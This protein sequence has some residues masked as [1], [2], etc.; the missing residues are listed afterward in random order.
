M[1][2][3]ML[4]AFLCAALAMTT[5]GSSAQVPAQETSPGPEAAD[6]ALLFREDP[7][8]EPDETR[9]DDISADDFSTFFADD[10]VSTD[11][12]YDVSDNDSIF[13]DPFSEWELMSENREDLFLTEDE[14]AITE[15]ADPLLS[16]EEWDDLIIDEDFFIEETTIEDSLALASRLNA[17]VA[18]RATMPDRGK[19]NVLGICVDFADTSFDSADTLDAFRAL[20][21][22]SVTQGDMPA[23]GFAGPYESLN[24]Y[25]QRSSLGLLDISADVFS[26]HS[27][28]ER[29]WYEEDSDEEQPG[30]D[31]IES[32]VLEVLRALDQDV[33]YSRYD[34]DGD[35]IIDCVFIHFAGGDTGWSSTWWSYANG[36]DTSEAAEQVSYDG[37]KPGAYV[38][39]H[40][41]SDQEAACRT[42]IHET[43]HTLGLP[44]Y[45]AKPDDPA[46][47]SKGIDTFDMMN[48]NT[49]EHNG[50][51]KWILGWLPADKV[52]MVT[53]N[54]SGITVT[55]NGTVIEQ[56]FPSAEGSP[57]PEDLYVEVALAPYTSDTLTETG[58]IVVVSNGFSE[59]NSGK[60]GSF[61]VMQYD[62]YAGNQAVYV[63]GS[64]LPAGLRIYRVQSQ[65]GD[66]GCFLY[67]NLK[68][69]ANRNVIELVR[70]P[71]ESDPDDDD[72]EDTGE[73]SDTARFAD[74]FFPDSEAVTPETTPSTNFFG[75]IE[76]GFTGLSFDLS[77]GDANGGKVRIIYSSKN[78]PSDERLKIE[79]LDQELKGPGIPVRFSLSFPTSLKSE[80]PP[81]TL[82]SRDEQTGQE[83]TVAYA[84][85]PEVNGTQASIRFDPDA[86]S[87]TPNRLLYLKIP[88][89][90]FTDKGGDPSEETL[91]P[92]RV[93][94]RFMPLSASGQA[95]GIITSFPANL[96]EMFALPGIKRGCFNIIDDRMQLCVFDPADLSAVTAI[97][98][99][100]LT[101]TPARIAHTRVTESGAVEV[102]FYDSSF[103]LYK[104]TVDPSAGTAEGLQEC[105]EAIPDSRDELYSR[106]AEWTSWME[107]GMRLECAL[108]VGDSLWVA[109]HDA[110]W[111]LCLG[112]LDPKASM[113]R[114]TVVTEADLSADQYSLCAGPAG[115]VALTCSCEYT[116]GKVTSQI[117]FLYD[118][119]LTFA[120]LLGVKSNGCCSWLDDGRFLAAGVH[121]NTEAIS[122]GTMPGGAS[123]PVL[124]WDVTEPTG[125]SSSEEGED[126]SETQTEPAAEVPGDPTTSDATEVK[127]GEKRLSDNG[128][129][130]YIPLSD[131]NAAYL[132]SAD[133]KAKSVVIPASVQLGG[134]AYQV[135]R[136]GRQAFRKNK[137]L[138]RVTIGK[139]V[140]VIG[141]GAF[142][143]CSRLRKVI[144]KTKKL[145]TV[146][147]KAFSGAGGK[148]GKNLRVKVPGKKLPAYRKKLVKAGL[149]RKAKLTD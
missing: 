31:R 26:Y 80:Y 1:S 77:Q 103:N 32:L 123:L 59:E 144:I 44:D 129:A 100:G 137:A 3:R 37:K 58:G 70:P 43:G 140:R 50:F 128:K 104:C 13:E 28:H 21:G 136:V 6:E 85:R 63:D 19:A 115:Q 120:G 40:N 96:S 126:K 84:D 10:A 7:Y 72:E 15:A 90:M 17:G 22:K 141:S 119:D 88:A 82:I 93:S 68:G 147:K 134:K 33:D 39:L 114:Q 108:P 36:F 106:G 75:S 113:V 61:Y 118:S 18:W 110:D 16:D 94:G 99:T 132:E 20:F 87:L 25:Y 12:V 130:W 51:S 78:R 66:D 60:Y 117:S 54:D 102:M 29:S 122:M 71:V 79:A 41:P 2:K 109:W 95:S 38:M 56:K 81:I 62:H 30:G 86:S 64:P 48:N 23:T 24:A 65:L 47:Q 127:I 4:S 148:T 53:A 57:E 9:P 52:T 76:T 69:K 131:K 116:A 101:V 14:E 145:R 11:D 74:M 105:A 121:I 35:G 67:D 27:D 45:Y 135:T 91:L 83:I 133:K 73:E 34:G 139:N 138:R 107:P 124:A 111:H 55:R 149:G 42:L 89:G 112:L 5:A 146:G 8:S 125:S 143:G 49:G 92:I 46:G 142:S 97:P 98:V